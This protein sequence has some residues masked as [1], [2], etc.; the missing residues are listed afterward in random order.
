MESVIKIEEGKGV[1]GEVE[2][3]PLRGGYPR[4]ERVRA[5]P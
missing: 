3:A 1:I 2:T 4:H 5:E